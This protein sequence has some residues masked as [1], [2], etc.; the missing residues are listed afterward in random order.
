MADISD[1]EQTI[2][3]VVAG[4]LYPAGAG[5][6]SVLPG[7]AAVIIHRG[8]PLANDLDRDLAAGRSH[9]S[10]WPR[11]GTEVN[12]SPYPDDWQDVFITPSTLTAVVQGRTV[13][14]GGHTDGSIVQFV[15][16]Q[17]GPRYVTSY[18]VLPTDTRESIAAALAS[19]ITAEFL[20][21]AAVGN[22]ITVTGTLAMR[23]IVGTTGSQLSVIRQQRT[24][25]QITLWCNT[26]VIR[27]AIG[28][29]VEPNLAD[30]TFLIMPDQSAAR[31][32]YSMTILN[33]NS[34]K[35]GLYRR[36]MIYNVEYATT[37]QDTAYTVTSV[38]TAVTGSDGLGDTGPAVQ[39]SAADPSPPPPK[40]QPFRPNTPN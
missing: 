15:T 31:F 17:I 4:I 35:E 2:V 11:G 12:T 24:Q 29:L 40:T 13:T 37:K 30:R 38:Q 5:Q 25:L 14:I 9:V 7:A 21:A 28:K 6:P 10:V 18:A 26:P 36:D 23:A 34:E 20:P 3:D 33:D 8:W 1:V 19:Q 39:L 16:L 27:D 22:V 32:R